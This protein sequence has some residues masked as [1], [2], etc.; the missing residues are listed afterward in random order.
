MSLPPNSQLSPL[1]RLRA[2]FENLIM[3]RLTPLDNPGG[4]FRWFF[5]AP[6]LFDRPGLRRFFPAHVLILTTTGRKSGKLRKTPLEYSYDPVTN[7]YQVMAGWGGKTDWYRNACAN[8]HVAVQ[9]GEKSFAAIAERMPD[10]QVVQSLLEITRMNP[11]SLKIWSRW[12]GRPLDGSEASLRAAAPSFPM[13][14]LHPDQAAH[15]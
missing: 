1:A 15:T 7:T 10:E 2:G 8:P 12:A 6:L 4:F 5:K 13:L 14:E 11:G 9:V 3:T